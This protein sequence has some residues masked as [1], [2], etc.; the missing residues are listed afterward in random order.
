MV[1]SFLN[2]KKLTIFFYS[3]LYKKWEV[4]KMNFFL[5]FSNYI[6]IN[7]TV[8]FWILF[9]VYTMAFI[10]MVSTEKRVFHSP[11]PKK[12]LVSL[13][14]YCFPDNSKKVNFRNMKFKPW[15]VYWTASA[16]TDNDI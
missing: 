14:D 5:K 11:G 16:Y 15:I 8:Y 7:L 6:V 2:K 10:V 3:Y 1:Y 9:E 4:L 12:S 13:P